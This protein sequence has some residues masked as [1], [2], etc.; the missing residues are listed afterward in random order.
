MQCDG[1]DD[2]ALVG[3]S[4]VVGESETV[5]D[6]LGATDGATPLYVLPPQTQQASAILLPLCTEIEAGSLFPKAEFLHVDPLC[7]D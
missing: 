2:G 1:C 4:G 3:S 5:G 6:A 7:R